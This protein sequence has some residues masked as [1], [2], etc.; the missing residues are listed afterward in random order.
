[1]IT[2]RPDP[3]ILGGGRRGQ[4][5]RREG[6]QFLTSRGVDGNASIEISFGRPHL[7]GHGESLEHLVAAQADEVDAHDL[8]LGQEGHDLHRGLGLVFGRNLPRT[9]EHIREGSGVG[10][11]LVSSVFLDSF[12]LGQSND[13][14]GRVREDDCGHILI[15]CS[16]FFH[17]PEQS[18]RDRM[19]E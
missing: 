1:M 14:D 9:V 13:A 4:S 3:I 8:L 6:D 18:T 7:H 5:P 2:I 10:L 15:I 11:D 16:G 12:L 17:I 19:I